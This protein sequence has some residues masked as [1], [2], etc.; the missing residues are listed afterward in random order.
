M[1][2]QP[3]FQNLTEKNLQKREKEK[4]KRKGKKKTNKEREEKEEEKEEGKKRERERK[5]NLFW[6]W[7]ECLSLSEQGGLRVTGLFFK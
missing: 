7:Q 5:K 2:K 6:L 4:E 3:F 1:H